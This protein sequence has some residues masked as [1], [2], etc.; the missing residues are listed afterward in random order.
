MSTAI[1]T[2]PKGNLSAEEIHSLPS[3]LLQD[4]RLRLWFFFFARSKKMLKTRTP[5][6]WYALGR[7][8]PAGQ[9]SDRVRL[10]RI[11]YEEAGGRVSGEF[12]ITPWS[13]EAI[14]APSFT[15]Q[16]MIEFDALDDD[17][18]AMLSVEEFSQAVRRDLEE[19]DQGI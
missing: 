7:A 11:P 19:D 8:L 5:A 13:E 1:D 10:V 9:P 15:P 17:E 6:E 12:M 18:G 4:E 2:P 3:Q 16:Q 14:H